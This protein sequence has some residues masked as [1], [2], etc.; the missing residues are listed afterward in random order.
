M[1]SKKPT[2]VKARKTASRSKAPKK[3]APLLMDKLRHDG[4]VGTGFGRS[5]AGTSAARRSG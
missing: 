3:A 1:A 4:G 5:R 2:R